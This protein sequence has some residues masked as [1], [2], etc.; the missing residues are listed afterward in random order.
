MTGT[1]FYFTCLRLGRERL[2]EGE[3]GRQVCSGED[4]GVLGAGTRVVAM[5]MEESRQTEEIG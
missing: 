1:D 3:E 5:E 2:P 4:E